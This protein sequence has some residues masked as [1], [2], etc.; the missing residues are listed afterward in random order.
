MLMLGTNQTAADK[1]MMLIHS[2]LHCNTDLLGRKYT[3]ILSD[4]AFYS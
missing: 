1:K 4:P 2:S 3:L